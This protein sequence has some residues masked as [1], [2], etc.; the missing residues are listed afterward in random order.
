MQALL[1]HHDEARWIRY[2]RQK[3]RHLFPYL[4]KQP[5]YNKRLRLLIPQIQH[6]VRILVWDTDLW[7][8]PLRV[9]DSTPVECGR[10]RETVK[11]S[12]L[13]GWASYGYCASH[14]RRFWGLRL[15]LITTVHGLPVAFAL[16]NP[17]TDE[18]EVLVDLFE[19][20]PGLLT[21]P[22]G[23]ILVV[24]KGYR[25]ADTE[26]WLGE[27]GVTVVRPAYN[28]EKPRPGRVL[29]RAVRQSIESV[30]QTFKGQLDLEQHGGHTP[31][32]VAVRVLQRVLA[33]TAAI[34]HNWHSGQPIMRSLVA[35]DH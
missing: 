3:L 16:T 17:K 11:R 10:S 28:G 20:E 34:W 23:L 18:R 30:N 24:D 15:H 35:F 6:L 31:E 21:H 2:A 8:H 26:T 4:P 25:D 14:S 19:L 7:Q 33:L 9:A 13:A 29:L 12:G 22:D 1:G 32:G 27:R 5:G